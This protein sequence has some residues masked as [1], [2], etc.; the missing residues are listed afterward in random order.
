MARTG[1]GDCW[2]SLLETARNFSF[3]KLSTFAEGF[4]SSRG[5]LPAPGE[6][7]SPAALG[8]LRRKRPVPGCSSCIPESWPER[9]FCRWSHSGRG[10]HN[11]SKDSAGGGGGRTGAPEPP[12]DPV[13]H[14][15]P[16]RDSG[17]PDL[18]SGYSRRR[19]TPRRTGAPVQKA[20]EQL[21]SRSSREST[22]TYWLDGRGA[23]LAGTETSGKR[24]GRAQSVPVCPPRR[25]SP[26]E[27]T[28]EMLSV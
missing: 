28:I 5:N 4:S 8:N 1:A 14:A 11:R 16:G 19:Y 13:F 25:E 2:R 6:L 12:S 27:R 15:R 24:T 9:G 23:P 26:P 22:I 21:L 3:G 18:L 20:F 7:S 10:A 17:I